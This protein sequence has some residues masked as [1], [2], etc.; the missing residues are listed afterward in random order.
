MQKEMEEKPNKKKWK[1]PQ[2]IHWIVK[3]FSL[4]KAVR[5]IK[6]IN[7]WGETKKNPKKRKQGR[8]SNNYTGQQ[9]NLI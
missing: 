1:Y 3:H 5:D 4:S 8:S 9:Q 6:Q 2:E 7:I